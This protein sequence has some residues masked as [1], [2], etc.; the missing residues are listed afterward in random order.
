MNLL[1]A[2]ADFQLPEWLTVGTLGTVLASF[3]TMIV[4]L[5]RTGVTNQ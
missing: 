5:I 2:I 4:S 3:V 1:V